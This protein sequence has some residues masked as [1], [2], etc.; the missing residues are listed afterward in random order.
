MGTD[1]GQNLMCMLPRVLR[2]AVITVVLV[3]LISLRSVSAGEGQQRG[4]LE[5]SR[6]LEEFVV[7]EWLS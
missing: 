7:D 1:A 3:S 4:M 2:H 5:S 6:R